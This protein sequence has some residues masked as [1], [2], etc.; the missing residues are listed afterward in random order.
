MLP[1]GALEWAGMPAVAA[2]IAELGWHVQVQ[3]NGRELPERVDLLSS[4]ACPVVID[5]VGRFM[6]PVG[7]DDASFAALL[8][9][10]DTGCCWVKL[11]APYESVPDQA[12]DHA[13]VSALVERLVERH[14]ERMLWATNWPHPGQAAPPAPD[15]LAT[16]LSRWLPT[17]TLRSQV[18]V[19]NPATLY[20]F[21]TP[22]THSAQEPNP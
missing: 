8:R 11:S 3:L 19:D 18:L 13:A 5:H 10:L 17:A 1:G 15:A 14:P 21:V 4:L 12:P 7:P 9:L 16:L 22:P 2:R 6:P 20:Q